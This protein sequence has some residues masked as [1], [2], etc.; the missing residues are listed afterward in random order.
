MCTL[1]LRIAFG[2]GVSLLHRR[3]TQQELYN[4]LRPHSTNLEFKGDSEHSINGMF[5]SETDRVSQLI[6]LGSINEGEW[7]TPWVKPS[8][9]PTAAPR[10]NE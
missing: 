7:S 2:F 6:L 1:Y 9:E 8:L 3:R 5:V 10:Q 4:L